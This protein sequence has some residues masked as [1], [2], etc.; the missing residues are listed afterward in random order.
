M[1]MLYCKYST[2]TQQMMA[3]TGLL[4]CIREHS[5]FVIFKSVD[6]A[7]ALNGSFIQ[8]WFNALCMGQLENIG[9]LSCAG[10]KMLTYFVIGYQYKKDHIC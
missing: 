6:L 7:C 4:N 5:Y 2:Q 8:V 1:D 9:L 10:H 3:Y